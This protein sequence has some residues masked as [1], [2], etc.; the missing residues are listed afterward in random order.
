MN[1]IDIVE[2]IMGP[3]PFSMSF[4]KGQVIACLT[5]AG[6]DTTGGVPM[7]LKLGT[8]GQSYMVYPVAAGT[9]K[10]EVKEYL[11]SQVDRLFDGIEITL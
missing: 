3:Y 10:E 11:C 1:K 7:V 8:S 2:A 5:Y 6:Q 4:E 9:T